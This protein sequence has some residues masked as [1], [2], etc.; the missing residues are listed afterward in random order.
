MPGVLL[1][2]WPKLQYEQGSHL[3]NKDHMPDH[4]DQKALVS[5]SLKLSNNVFVR[6]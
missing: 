2:V 1:F 3:K 5:I 4:Q 6:E